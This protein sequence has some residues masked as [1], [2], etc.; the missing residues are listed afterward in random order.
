MAKLNADKLKN[1]ARSLKDEQS[2]IKKAGDAA[3]Q[4]EVK[5]KTLI[6]DSKASGR[7]D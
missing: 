4:S 3:K 6:N 7:K 1:M 2:G 5:K